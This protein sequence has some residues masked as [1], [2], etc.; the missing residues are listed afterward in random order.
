MVWGWVI[1]CTSEVLRMFE[2]GNNTHD[3]QAFFTLCVGFA[4]GGTSSIF[5]SHSS[6][7]FT[8]TF[9]RGLQR[10]SYQWRPIL[11]GC[12]ALASTERSVRVLGHWLVQPLRTSRCHDGYQVRPFLY[13]LVVPTDFR[14]LQLCLCKLHLDRKYPRDWLCPY[15]R[16]DHWYLRSCTLQSRYVPSQILSF[17]LSDHLNATKV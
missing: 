3:L 10:T 5:I 16:K 6:P 11:L 13:T 12:N 1:V 17:S 8:M 9:Y 2:I 7:F 4:M 14:L 15:P